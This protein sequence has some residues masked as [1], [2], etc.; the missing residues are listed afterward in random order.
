MASF[1][2]CAEGGRDFDK[3]LEK[4]PLPTPCGYTRIEYGSTTLHGAWLE[5]FG[6]PYRTSKSAM[7]S[8][9]WIFWDRTGRAK[10]SLPALEPTNVAV[11]SCFK[12]NSEKRIT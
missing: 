1:A 12:G 9:M 10:K 2:P 5:V 6:T 7:T 4:V 3:G 8:A 11:S